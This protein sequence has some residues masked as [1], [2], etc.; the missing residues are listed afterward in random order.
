M[1][2]EGFPVSPAGAGER[3][4]IPPRDWHVGRVTVVLSEEVRV[5]LKAGLQ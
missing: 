1:R 5:N 3:G 2:V 4:M